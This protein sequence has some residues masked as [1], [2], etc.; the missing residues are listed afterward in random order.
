MNEFELNKIKTILVERRERVR[1][2][3]NTP[4]TK[5]GYINL[6]KEIDSALERMDKGTYGICVVCHD[7]IEEDR[8]L[9]NP[10][11][12]VCL[13][14]M[15][16][17][18]RRSLE[19]DLDLAN[20]MQRS[21]LPKNNLA[22]PHWEINYHYEPAGIV[23]GDYCDIIES[24]E[25]KFFI[26]GDVSG[27]G[28][29]ASMLMAHLHAMFHSMISLGLGVAEL[30][31]RANRLM[32]ES[33]SSELYAT[34]ICIKASNDGNLEIC[35]AGHPHPVIVSNKNIITPTAN[36]IPIG[37]FCDSEYSVTNE[38][39]E[40]GDS[41]F[42]YTDGLTESFRGDEEFGIERVSKFILENHESPVK[43]LMVDLL[44]E[45]KTF[46]DDEKG[47]DDLTMMTVRKL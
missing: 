36:G 5:A 47:K 45:V 31:Q 46:A 35:N 1:Q 6:L 12:N 2:V 24:G 43:D 20:K 10:L 21:M 15:D 11:V 41:L 26:L 16:E 29:A 27:K 44:A 14:D 4:G 30:V 42:L 8:L 38:K 37:L 9:I 17:H 25:N 33:T 32:C 3:V 34:L 13:G 39:L 40:K 23:S 19:S 28:I 22:T 18:Q 7:P